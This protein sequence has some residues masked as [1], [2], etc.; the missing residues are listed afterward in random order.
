MPNLGD[1]L[2]QLLSEI[3]IARMHA[4]LEAVRVAELYASHPLLRTMPVPHFRLPEVEVDVPVV[5]KQME[6]PR[7][8]ESARGGI[9][10]ADLRK[11]FDQVLAKQLLKEDIQTTPELKNKLR[12]VLDPRIVALSQPMDV[13]VDVN[14][15]ADDLS[16]AAS[17]TL[18]ELGQLGGGGEPD[19]LL[20]FE[21]ELKEAARVE[22]L[23]LRRPPPRL[24]VL[25]TTQEIRE[26]GPSELV[27]RIKLR[28]NEHGLEWTSLETQGRMQ[29]RLVPE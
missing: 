27:T 28:I 5:I 8:D 13:A 29:D 6:E 22:S 12:S 26:A 23:K 14:R 3:T 16:S 9:A 7:A 20:K 18:R 11:A 1:Y 24:Q 19:R 21:K 25:V 17:R 4:D 15:V 10:I 2:G